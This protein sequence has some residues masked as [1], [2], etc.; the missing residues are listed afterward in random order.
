VG[1]ELGEV[2]V[3]GGDFEEGQE[4]DQQFDEEG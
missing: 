2:L 1:E 3:D 4:G